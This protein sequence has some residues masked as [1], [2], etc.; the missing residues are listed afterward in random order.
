MSFIHPFSDEC[1]T[2]QLD[3][4]KIPS[5]ITSIDSE[6]FFHYKPVAALTSSNWIEF[7]ISGTEEFID[8]S[9]ILLEL[10]IDVKMSDGLTSLPNE[11]SKT[12]TP[13][14]YEALVPVNNFMSSIF[15]Q[16]D[17][18]L[19][20]TLVT[21][22]TNLYRY[23]SYLD[24]LFYQSEKSKKTYM[25]SHFWDDSSE[26]RKARFKRV[27][28][29]KTLKLIGPLH[30]DLSQQERLLLNF[31]DMN[32]RLNISDPSFCFILTGATTDRPSIK[33][34]NATLHVLKKKLFSDCEA[35]ILKALEKDTC[36]YFYTN[37]QLRT[38]MIDS[39][40]T[41]TFF[42]NLFPSTLPQRFVMGLL[43]A[44]A[45]N[46]EWKED[47]FA[48]KH[49]NLAEIKIFV[50]SV[51]IPV[52][53]LEIDIANDDYARAYHSFYHSMYSTHPSSNLSITPE[54]FKENC[55]FYAF[56]LST[57]S[58]LEDNETVGLIRRGH[59]RVDLRFKSPTTEHLVLLI[60]SHFPQVLQIDL[61]REVMVESV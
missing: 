28:S 49:H 27:Y 58:D 37:T 36:K 48:F 41:S 53:A 61:A 2:S 10:E 55:T 42:D 20:N 40:I 54:Q 60:Y 50:D 9:S 19:S 8:L 47:P 34:A 16:V 57:D 35:G 6:K 17:L 3:L 23:R 31:V 4:F 43:S 44:K 32:L 11:A 14:L 5:S 12:A 21:S 33:I 52:P 26:K 59:V 24:N 25:Y 22:A 18:Y 56:T 13:N 7:R 29:G 30:L 38:R 45:F 15:Q 1:T 51:Q 39:G 46:G